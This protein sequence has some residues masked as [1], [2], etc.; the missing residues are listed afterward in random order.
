MN[1]T[2]TRS[3]IYKN[4]F[5]LLIIMSLGILLLAGSNYIT[6]LWWKDVLEKIGIAILSSGVFASVLKSIQF[7]G[8][9]KE[10]VGK[11]MLETD[12][13]KNRRDLPDLWSKISKII[14]DR[15]FKKISKDLEQI[16]LDNYFPTNSKFYY[17]DYFVTI[18]IDKINKDF[19]V[20]YTQTCSY[21]VIVA[22]NVDEITLTLE[23]SITQE[24]DAKSST[25]VN[26]LEYF[27]VNGNPQK[28]K[29][30]PETVNNKNFS[31]YF[32]DIKGKGPHKIESKYNRKYSLKN[33]NYKLFRLNHFTKN[34]DVAISYP[35]D[36]CVSFFNIGLIH[37]FDPV[38]VEI[39][40]QIYRKHRKSLIFP[41]QGF[42]MSFEKK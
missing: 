29:E 25:I 35:K 1:W 39:E 3:W 5:W 41:K 32:M 36:I 37:K 6:N 38:H 34:M 4:L 30:D 10:E 13:I 42:G 19:E 20:S 23:T 14:Y 33:E 22:K 7:T 17:K 26:E 18:N 40:N 12:F 31:R 15:K 16:I 9:F 8:I 27:T 21:D 2:K 24:D 11:V 28:T